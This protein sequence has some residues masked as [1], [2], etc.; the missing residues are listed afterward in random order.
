MLPPRLP[1]L[2]PQVSLL[3][4]QTPPSMSGGSRISQRLGGEGCGEPTYVLK[5]KKVGPHL[6]TAAPRCGY[7]PKEGL[8]C[9]LCQS[10]V[11]FCCKRCGREFS[12][13]CVHLGII[14][15]L[16]FM[17]ITNRVARYKEDYTMCD[18]ITPDCLITCGRFW[19]HCMTGNV[20]DLLRWNHKS[21]FFCR[22]SLT[23]LG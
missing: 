16:E 4:P 7:Q 18:L 15:Q 11:V 23:L 12:A 13:C 2:T 5:I 10:L 22:C 14:T 8:T 1:P 6:L 17:N 19:T 21:C 3:C 9:C 20:T